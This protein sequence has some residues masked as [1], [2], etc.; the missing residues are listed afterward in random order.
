[1][2]ILIFI[3]IPFILLGQNSYSL[4][5]DG[6][7][8]IKKSI[9]NFR[10]SD[11]RG[12]VSM[13][14][15]VSAMGSDRVMFSTSDEAGTNNFIQ[16]GVFNSDT[17]YN[18][19]GKH[20]A[21]DIRALKATTPAPMTLNIWYHVVFESNNSAFKITINGTARTVS[22]WSGSNDGNWL[23]HCE[24]R[25][26]I[27]IGALERTSVINYYSGLIDEVAVFS[28]TLTTTQIAAIYNNGVPND[29]SNQD[30][31]VNYWRF[32]TGSGTSAIPTVGT[33]TLTF[34]AGAAAPSW[35]STTAGWSVTD[36]A[37]KKGYQGIKLYKDYSGY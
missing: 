22:A 33:D 28:D 29:I 10:G 4:S 8:Y 13:W 31:L 20:G 12:A 15:Q 35:S 11:T 37:D 16:V 2:K 18:Y 34:G 1:M 26:N 19:Y 3:F 14:F 5:F 7:D 24:L 32:E 36:T 9:A 17:T 27:M 30:N 21:G 25:D 6:G 23:D